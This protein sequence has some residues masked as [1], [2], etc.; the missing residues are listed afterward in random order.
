MV[1]VHEFDLLNQNVTPPSMVFSRCRQ[2]ISKKSLINSSFKGLR[3]LVWHFVMFRVMVVRLWHICHGKNGRCE[4]DCSEISFKL[5]SYPTDEFFRQFYLQKWLISLFLLYKIIN[6][7]V[8]E[9]NQPK[10][11]YCFQKL[12]FSHFYLKH[13]GPPYNRTTPSPDIW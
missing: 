1:I 9:D 10:I 4:I 5:T 13:L 12:I 7:E 3:S 2:N 6:Y 8:K 11:K